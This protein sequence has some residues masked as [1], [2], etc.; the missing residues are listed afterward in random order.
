MFKKIAFITLFICFYCNSYAQQETKTLSF[1]PHIGISISNLT[2]ANLDAKTGFVAGMNLQYQLTKNFGFVTGLEYSNYGAKDG[3]ANL[4][5]GY[6]DLPILGKYY[7][8]K[9]L[10]TYAGLQFG[11]NIYDGRTDFI[12]P[13]DA[14]KIT[15]SIPIGISYDFK[16][17]S[18]N[19]QYFFGLSNV[20][21]DFKYKN[22][23]IKLTIGYKINNTHWQN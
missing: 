5:L 17:F 9:G 3:D 6:I 23:G 16:H 7:I 18:I 10:S 12:L 14:K 21:N 15:F 8:Y 1:E 2:N 22:R 19:G 4:T 11:Y 13:A 20:Y